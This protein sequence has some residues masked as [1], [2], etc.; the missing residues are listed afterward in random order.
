LSRDLFALA[1]P[2]VP[3]PVQLGEAAVAVALL[4]LDRH[5][6]GKWVQ[7]QAFP[8]GIAIFSKVLPTAD[9]VAA[10]GAGVPDDDVVL[11]FERAFEPIDE[12]PV[13]ELLGSADQT[14]ESVHAGNCSSQTSAEPREPVTRSGRG[15]EQLVGPVDVEEPGM[16]LARKVQA[17]RAITILV[18]S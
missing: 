6:P 17:L 10:I 9:Q 2:D 15:Q 14:G 1:A 16:C 5:G 11:V 7:P 13:G 8:H 12:L 4:I 3:L 18:N